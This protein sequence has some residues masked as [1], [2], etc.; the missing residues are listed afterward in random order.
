MQTR[1]SSFLRFAALLSAG[2]S[3]LCFGQVKFEEQVLVS[4]TTSAE[5]TFSAQSG[6]VAAVVPKGSR[7]AVVYDGVEGPRFDSISTNG[8][9][10]F[11]GVGGQ[12]QPIQVM[13]PNQRNALGRQLSGPTAATRVLFNPQ[14]THYAYVGQS[15]NEQVI[16]LDGKELHRGEYLQI[17]FLA[18]TP[19][20][21]RLVAKGLNRD[22]SQSR[23]IIDGQP[24]P[25][26]NGIDSIFVTP[27]G[28][29]YAY[30]GTLPDGRTKWMVVDGKQTK[31]LGEIV[32]FTPQGFLFTRATAN[33]DT[34]LLGN[35]KP[36]TQVS[37]INHLNISSKTGKLIMQVTPP[38]GTPPRNKPSVLTVDGQ[39]IPGTEGVSVTRSWFSPDGK[40]YA[41]LCQR[42][43]GGQGSFMIVDGKK[44]QTYT[45]IYSTDTYAPSFSPDSTKLVYIGQT[46]N[47]TFIVE[48]GE[49]SDALQAISLPPTWSS[50]S[51]RLAWSGLTPSNNRLFFVDGKP[52]ALPPRTDPGGTFSFTPDGAHTVWSYGNSPMLTLMVDNAPIAGV[53]GANLIGADSVDGQNAT[54]KLSPDG[55]HMAYPGRDPKNISRQGI[56]VDG[57]FI[58]PYTLPQVNRI[59][60]TPD[61]QHVFWAVM[62]TKDNRAAYRVFADGRE[63]L[64][65]HSSMA[66]VATGTWAMGEDGTLTFLGADGPAFKRYRIPPPADSSIT[67]MLASAK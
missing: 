23:V 48:N 57:K 65:Y 42:L 66:D 61:S 13:R 58:T 49:E 56:Y 20:G 50:T 9:F 27:D 24:G 55:K 30:L 44:E 21:E 7:Q 39:I 2:G 41:V 31:Y 51:S 67:T 62:T 52:V 11:D 40:R 64:T 15:G 18:F 14:G 43:D 29:H 35:G 19:D 63:V 5:I 32:G 3:S 38:L 4:D 34:I 10:A 25:W 60:F 17:N 22:Q 59:T 12:S 33:G 54:V 16:M 36:M 28:K 53:S 6:H 8:L 37:S 1:I 46:S 47:G 45:S 26:A